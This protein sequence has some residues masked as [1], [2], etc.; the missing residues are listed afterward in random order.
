M[1]VETFM[2]GQPLPAPAQ[3]HILVDWVTI[4]VPQ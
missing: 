4:D 3:G 1:Q 2:A